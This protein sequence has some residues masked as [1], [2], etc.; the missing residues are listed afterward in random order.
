MTE[1]C[2]SLAGRGLYRTRFGSSANFVG[3]S[4]NCPKLALS[5]FSHSP[6]NKPLGCT[7]KSFHQRTAKRNG[8]A[9]TNDISISLDAFHCSVKFEPI[10]G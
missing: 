9:T 8:V 2:F 5:D 3:K 4:S 6:D 10:A 7:G 1:L